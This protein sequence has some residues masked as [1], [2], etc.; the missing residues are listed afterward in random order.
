M[1]DEERTFLMIKPDGVLRGLVGE[2]LR[3]LEL[4]GLK[5]VGLKLMQLDRETAERHYHEHE[6]KSYFEPLVEYISSAPSVVMVL[7]GRS[8]ISVVRRM[9]GPTDPVQADPGTLRGDLALNRTS[10]VYN[11]VHASDSPESAEKE[12]ALFFKPDEILSYSLPASS[13]YRK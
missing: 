11:L 13:I 7:E 2:V 6:G 1:N 12:I 8:A 10:V 3:R 5:I 9:I 4:K